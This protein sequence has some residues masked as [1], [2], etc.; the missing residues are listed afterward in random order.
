M[1]NTL[2]KMDFDKPA[3]AGFDGDHLYIST[4]L[5]HELFE[6]LKNAATEER[7]G[8]KGYEVIPLKSIREITLHQKENHF[9]FR[10]ARAGKQKKFLLQIDDSETR[11]LFC[12]ELS[13]AC[14]LENRT[15]TKNP[16]SRVAVNSIPIMMTGLF[17]LGCFFGA[18]IKGKGS[19]RGYQFG[20]ALKIIGPIPILI[21]GLAIMTFFVIRLMR[22]IKASDTKIVYRT[23]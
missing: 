17:T 18:L 13:K 10:Y 5:G 2:V 6:T 20:E 9:T 19:G 14:R 11:L 16:Y 22:N 7:S 8:R 21:I 23:N 3:C 15:E 12:E 1:K 4:Q